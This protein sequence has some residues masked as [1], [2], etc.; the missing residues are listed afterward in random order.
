MV[1]STTNKTAFPVSIMNK[2]VSH[3]INFAILRFET[4]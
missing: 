4:Q 1:F 2:F 3:E